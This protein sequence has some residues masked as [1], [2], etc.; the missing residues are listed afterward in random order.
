MSTVCRVRRGTTED[1]TD[2][3]GE[4]IEVLRIGGVR[5]RVVQHGVREASLVQRR[6]EGDEGIATSREVVDRS[7]FHDEVLLSVPPERRVEHMIREAALEPH[8]SS[9]WI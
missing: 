8:S 1:L 5:E 4:V 6:G 9:P 3:V 7:F 2:V